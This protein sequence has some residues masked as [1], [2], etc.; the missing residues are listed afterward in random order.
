MR[1]A[2]ASHCNYSLHTNAMKRQVCSLVP[3]YFSFRAED[4][5][6]PAALVAARFFASAASL[7]S[8]PAALLELFTRGLFAA[9]DRSFPAL[10]PLFIF[11]AEGPEPDLDFFLGLDSRAIAPFSSR[12]SAMAPR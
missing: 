2:H 12:V 9:G 3:A 4:F 10:A 7:F 1:S 5:S 6:L 11:D 8:A